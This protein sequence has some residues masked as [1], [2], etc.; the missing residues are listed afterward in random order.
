MV[1]TLWSG[2]TKGA[3]PSVQLSAE[4]NA[5][6]ANVEAVGLFEG[7]ADEVLVAPLRTGKIESVK[8]NRGGSSISLRIEFDN[9]S[10]A[11]FKPQQIN[12]Q[13]VPRREV[14][15][16][17]IN[18]ML[19]LSSVSPAIGRDFSAEEIIGK[20]REDSRGFGPRI[21]EEI[22]S[23]KGRVIGE[24]SWW[25]PEIK[26]ARIGPYEIDSNEGVVT[27]SRYLTVGYAIPQPERH[28]V[29]QL[30]QLVLFDFII[31]NV[32]R[33]TGRNVF[34]SPDGRRLYFMDNTLSFR[35]EPD[36]TTR[37]RAYLFKIQRV[38]RSLISAIEGLTRDKV[39]AALTRDRGSF[40]E[41]LTAG[42]IDAM[43][44]RRDFVLKYVADLISDHGRSAV[45]VF[46]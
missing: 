33:W 34:S 46:P 40:E 15:A 7:V 2:V 5:A 19:G 30:S 14:A 23:R 26:I 41:L 36:G 17:R 31:D 21:R 42:E 28:M 6:I 3:D 13:T 22:I 16:Y 27:W 9:G 44:G 38:S 35:V 43:L 8:F 29:T 45:M 20:L 18:R 4:N 1:Q 25:I 24:L 11:A 37:T 32:D 10:R 12:T 39:V